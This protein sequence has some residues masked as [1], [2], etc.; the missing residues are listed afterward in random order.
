MIFYVAKGHN[1]WNNK[2]LTRAFRSLAEAEGFING[3]TDGKIYRHKT[4]DAVEAIN[5]AFKLTGD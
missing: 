1:S 3:L 2:D 4:K 5:L